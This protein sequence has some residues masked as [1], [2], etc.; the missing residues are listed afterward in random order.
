LDDLLFLE[1]DTIQVPFMYPNTLNEEVRNVLWP[2][3][4]RMMLDI[5]F[6][7]VEEQVDLRRAEQASLDEE[8]V[9]VALATKAMC[10]EIPRVLYGDV[11]NCFKSS[12]HAR[13]GDSAAEPTSHRGKKRKRDKQ[14][15]VVCLSNFRKNS[16]VKKLPGCGHVFHAKCIDKCFRRTAIKCPVC[17]A[18]VALTKEITG[19]Q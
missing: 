5:G 6:E 11:V 14:H 8:S 1:G 9:D 3:C 7:Y 12:D 4:L 15:C 2:R 13:S 17:R 19:Y 16:K 18:P 10:K